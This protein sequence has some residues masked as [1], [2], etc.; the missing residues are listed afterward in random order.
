MKIY[1]FIL[2]LGLFAGPASEA[3]SC[4]GYVYA[5][6]S[7]VFSS[8]LPIDHGSI[9]LN[10]GNV[11]LE[12]PLP[13]APQRGGDLQYSSKL[14]YDSRIWT[15][16]QT[17]SSSYKWSATN[18][19]GT[20]GGW[21]YQASAGG[22]GTMVFDSNPGT[23]ANPNCPA[24]ST[25]QNYTQYHDWTWYAPDKTAHSFPFAST[26]Q[27]T[28]GNSAHC[29]NY[30]PAT[31][32]STAF[33]SD[34]SG[35]SLTLTNYTVPTITDKHGIVYHP[36]LIANYPPANSNLVTDRNGNY[37]STDASG[38]LLD[39]NKQTPVL[40]STSGNNTYYDVLGA[41][42]SRLR[43]TV[44]YT[45]VA[46]NT[47]FNE[48][49][50]NESTGGSLSAIQS[51]GLPDG[52]SYSFTYNN[53][54]YADLASMTLPT[55]GTV[56]LTYSMFYDSFKN[57][58]RWVTGVQRDG[59]TTTIT[60]AVVSQC[61]TSAGCQETQTVTTP[62]GNDTVYTFNL[63]K[64]G[65]IAGA[66]WIAG[67]TSYQGRVSAGHPL[68]TASTIYTYNTYGVTTDQ[69]GTNYVTGYF[70]NPAS[71]TQ[72]LSLPEAGISSQTVTTLVQYETD[73]S[74][75]KQSDWYASSQ[76]PPTAPALETLYNYRNAFPTA[77]SVK[78]GGGNLLAATTFGYDE[79]ATT[80][81]PSSTPNHTTG[82]NSYNLTTK[83]NYLNT[84]NSSVSTHYTYYD[85]GQIKSVT[86]PN[87]GTTNYGY[88]A[89]G[90]YVT[91]TTLPIAGLSTSAAYDVYTGV[92]L[93][94]TDLNGTS[95]N[96]ANYDGL[97]RPQ[98]VTKTD[99]SGNLV[100]KT[101]YTYSPTSV[102]M[103]VYQNAN[104]AS[105]TI[106]L[107]DGYGRVSRVAVANGESSNPWY[108]RDTC[109]DTNG[110]VK[111][112]SNPYVG[113]GF[114]AATVCS[115]NG[116]AVAYDGLG[117]TASVTSPD[118]A[119]QF[120]RVGP[121]TLV[122]D[123]N[124]LQKITQVDAFS[125]P[126]S[127]CEVSGT[128]YSGDSP[129]ACGL[130]I[131]G[132]G[133]L[134]T[135]SYSFPTLTTTVKQ[136][137]QT[138]T[139][140]HDSLGRSVQN[141]EPERG[142]TTYQYAYNATG[143]A[144]TRVRP[145]ANVLAP[146]SSTTQTVSQYDLLGRLLS[147]TY[148]DGTPTKTF[149]YDQKGNG[150][151]ISNAGA[152]KGRLTQ[153]SL[154]DSSHGRSY[155]YDA[156]GRIN[157][158]VECLPGW[159][160]GRITGRDVYRNYVYDWTGNLL[161][162]NYATQ[163]NGQNY[164]TVSYGYNV[165]GQLTAVSGGQ[166]D[167]SGSPNIYGVNPATMLPT[168]PQTETYGNGL[169]ASSQYDNLGRLQGRWLCGSP[170]G[171][172][173]PGS[174][175]YYGMVASKSGN[176]VQWVVDTVLNRFT[177]F[178]Y[179]DL[180]RLTTSATHPQSGYTGLAMNDTYDR[181]GN[182]LT[183]FVTNTGGYSP[184]LTF[185]TNTSTNQI[186]GFGY[187][188]AG[189]LISDGTNSYQFDAEN[190]LVAISGGSTAT[191]VYDEFNHR[192]SASAGGVTDRYGL[193]VAG[194]RSTTW[195]D[196][197]GGVKLMQYYNDQGPVAFWSAADGHIHFEHQDYLGTD[198]MITAFNGTQEGTIGSLPFGE[199]ATGWGA[200]ASPSHFALLDQDVGASAGLSHAA[201]RDYLSTEG[202]WLSPDPYNGSYKLSDP[203]SLNRYAYAENSPLMF[204]DPLGLVTLPPSS[205]G[206]DD[207][208]IATLFIDA[209][210]A[211]IDELF[212]SSGPSFKG[213]LTPRPSNIQ[214]AYTSPYRFQVNAYLSQGFYY[215]DP[216]TISLAIPIKP[217]T[218]TTPANGNLRPGFTP[219]DGVCS[220]GPLSGPM[221]A[222]PSVLACCQ[223]HDACYTQYQCNA[224][225]FDPRGPSGPCKSV[226]NSNV[227]ACVTNALVPV[228]LT[229]FLAF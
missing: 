74:D 104:T 14:V 134:T 8:Q 31:P 218:P 201:L 120:T 47:S 207:S 42:G 199:F 13:A 83:S 24:G 67:S 192:V 137:V 1:P 178:S 63:D 112:T 9:S 35:Y 72:T 204:S 138:R 99:S 159:C 29:L 52:S 172:N 73:P 141:N 65:L 130:D 90:T 194:R 123:K 27:W 75:V 56:K 68:Q 28:G 191:Y 76:S 109:Y 49:G 32:T 136:G 220:T 66:S 95:T 33:A 81:A 147:T 164:R 34:S 161:T 140:Q 10:N 94:I 48:P 170:G 209:I 216:G 11:H 211:L 131:P 43:Y 148:N 189:N 212:S 166:S 193:D 152:S 145:K 184:N 183:E 23:Y 215:S 79:V 153:M 160:D 142:S 228:V 69:N 173:C 86:D 162:D 3:V 190:N 18:G 71:I 223:V 26:I 168:G 213:T 98:L 169:V 92:P 78:D 114:S 210:D 221:N 37:W 30:P 222:I 117:R 7:P 229:L 180:G 188:G 118:G 19:G 128:K 111:F 200:D 208:V 174:Q 181:Y 80:V 57:M 38:N 217:A 165:A 36:T 40:V 61:S 157:Q 16:L 203:Q 185:N 110:R 39:T 122:K 82:I 5:T 64:A 100:G 124:N 51:I 113:P 175:Y 102:Q 186:S 205:G 179:D 85:T 182:H 224:S 119:V 12:I 59:A 46:F 22:V 121:A 45:T 6:G 225:S 58:N 2:V 15:I 154:S 97:N 197:G 77:I 214:D 133:Y 20:A 149:T 139:F 158:V 144:V 88:D 116:D 176:Q 219:Q 25:P 115:G 135:Y 146:N 91:S 227:E 101:I 202:R 106:T 195:L 150:G 129:A 206:G 41:A 151:S 171:V 126:I 93:G 54:S 96:Y 21:V 60:P 84:G 17:G 108:Q 50:V 70:E 132:T 226:C 155:G 167:A 127:I 62:D 103:Q 163:G 44:T 198:R 187:D 87:G 55:G 177:D 89:S 105:N 156:L 4:Q 143:L 196:N 125:R 53:G 107:L